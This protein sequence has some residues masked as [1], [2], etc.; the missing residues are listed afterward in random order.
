VG[1]SADTLLLAGEA[2]RPGGTVSVV[3]VFMEPVTIDPLPLLV[4]EATLAW[5]NCYD[6]P[7]EGADFETATRLVD[8]HR[9]A[10]ARL[11]THQV[12]LDEIDRGFRLAADRRAGAIKVTVLI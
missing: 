10:L 8:E 11:T 5:S 4:K 3:G 2:L 12:G 1:G 6:H 7:H 9:G